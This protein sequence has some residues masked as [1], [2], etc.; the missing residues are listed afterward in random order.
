MCGFC[1]H[2][3][4]LI[5]CSTCFKSSDPNYVA[6]WH[7]Y[8]VY[9]AFETKNVDSGVLDHVSLVYLLCHVSP[10]I[11]KNVKF[12]LYIKGQVY[13]LENKM[14][15][16]YSVM[17]LQGILL[18]V[19]LT[20]LSNAV[21]TSIATTPSHYDVA[22]INRSTFPAGFIFGTASSAYQVPLGFIS[23]TVIGS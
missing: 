2:Q 20:I 4:P 22:S 5:R 6:S 15:T 3:D 23:L 19:L 1:I 9:H 21:A 8:R 7:V 10:L 12:P 17:A 18:L 16:I 14:K 11:K 13:S